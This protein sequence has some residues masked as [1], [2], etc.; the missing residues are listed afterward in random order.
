MQSVVA[1]LANH[2]EFRLCTSCNPPFCFHGDAKF[3]INTCVL[4]QEAAIRRA[5]SSCFAPRLDPL[6]VE[7]SS[8][9]S[10]SS[11][12]QS[13]RVVSVLWCPCKVVEAE[14]GVELEGCVSRAALGHQLLSRMLWLF[15][16]Q[17][18]ND[19]WL[20]IKFGDCFLPSSPPTH[21]FNC[22]LF[23]FS[24]HWSCYAPL[25]SCCI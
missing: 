13:S 11:P 18:K 4:R 2:T 21:R 14:V 6:T 8:P 9:P 12:L 7:V 22:M 10:N 17:K 16:Q 15:V 1:E 19:F 5:R 25:N 3:L 23:S 24:F 20:N